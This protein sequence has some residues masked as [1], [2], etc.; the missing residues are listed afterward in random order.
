V[1]RSG[2]LL[3]ALGIGPGRRRAETSVDF[4]V[5]SLE[6]LAELF[7]VITAEEQ[8][9]IRKV[10]F[11][12]V[13]SCDIDQS[14]TMPGRLASAPEIADAVTL[15]LQAWGTLRVEVFV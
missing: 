15:G 14:D 5:E 13:V 8:S 9:H 4:G 11:R 2:K 1:Q 10:V 12:V 3:V 7:V 6:I